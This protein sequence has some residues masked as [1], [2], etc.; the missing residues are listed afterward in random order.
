MEFF[1]RHKTVVAFTAFTLFCI[2]SLSVQSSTFTW[3]ISGI[4]SAVVTPFQKMYYGVQDGVSRIW[5]GF[6]E[7]SEVR[8]E[9]KETRKKL[10][11]YEAKSGQAAEL[12][13]E[14]NRLRRLLGL[15]EQVIFDSIPATV[16][17]KDPD[18]WFRTIIINRGSDEGIKVN[19]PVIAYKNGQKA[20]VGKIS[21][22]RGSIS[23][24]Q[25]IISSDIKVGVKFYDTNFPGLLY[26]YSSN[27]NY[28]VM[29]YISRSAQ[30]KK[31]NMIITSG[32]GGVFP[33]GI[34][35]G[36]VIQ[37][38]VLESS[39]YQRAVVRPYIDYNLIEEVFVIKKDPDRELIDLLKGLK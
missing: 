22:V 7:L 26:G 2:I 32:Q 37:A 21:E 38:I 33:A 23:R 9:L 36:N 35:I 20:V 34:I 27:S 19:M 25:P 10:Q 8:E 15:K 30:I 1:I 24:I 11:E 6:T 14:N 29:D 39:A 18:N 12:R 28:C 5:A 13:E 31:G 3:S 16:I 17:S 4:G